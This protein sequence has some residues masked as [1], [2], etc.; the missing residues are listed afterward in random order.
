MHLR[1]GH[2]LTAGPTGA[3][4][5][6]FLIWWILLLFMLRIGMTVVLPHWPP[7]RDLIAEIFARLKERTIGLL[8]VEDAGEMLRVIARR[9]IHFSTDDNILIQM[10]DDRQF[11]ERALE[12]CLARMTEKNLADSPA[13]EKYARLAI[14]TVQDANRNGANIPDSDVCY[15]IVPGHPAY[16]KALRFCTRQDVIRELRLIADMPTREY[17]TMVES[18]VRLLEPVYQSPTVIA[19]TQ[20]PPTFDWAAFHRAGG[21]HIITKGA[22]SDEDFRVLQNADF[23][24]KYRLALAGQLGEHRYCIDEVNNYGLANNFVARALSTTRFVK[25]FIHLLVQLFDWPTEEIGRNVLSNTSHVIFQQQDPE[26][27]AFFSRDLM[28]NLSRN[29]VHHYDTTTR[30]VHDGFDEIEKVSKG[31]TSKGGSSETVSTQL[32]A[33]YKEVPESRPVYEAPEHQVF[34]QAQ[35]L[36]QLP[37]GHCWI[38]ELRKPP[39]FLQVP[40]VRPSFFTHTVEDKVSQCLTMLLASAPYETP[41]YVPEAATTTSSPASGTNERSTFSK[42]TPRRRNS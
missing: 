3:G 10:R 23:L 8:I 17:M 11:E 15:V 7:A 30:Q 26:M 36:G 33:R 19:R 9:F 39:V 20:N 42:S 5:S 21:I 34:W 18:A 37:V 12:P 2:V 25:F 1:E 35:A 28:G 40:L 24:T 4:K 27:A 31:K 16:A 22:A 6:N 14:R 32:V 29:A 41:N 38:K 13:K